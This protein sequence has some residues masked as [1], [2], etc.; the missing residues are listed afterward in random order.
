MKKMLLPSTSATCALQTLWMKSQG[1]GWG[2]RRQAHGEGVSSQAR[3]RPCPVPGEQ[4]PS[5]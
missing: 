1:C 3:S 2:S 5:L 4:E